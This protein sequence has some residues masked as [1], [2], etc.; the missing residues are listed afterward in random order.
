M[1]GTELPTVYP[2]PELGNL[3][4]SIC[5]DVRFPE[6]Y[7]H[8]AYKGADILFIPAAFTA[9]TGKDHGKCYCKQGQLKI[10][11]ML[12]RQPRQVNTMLYD[13]LTAML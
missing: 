4:I 2:S 13:R 6:L 5:Y 8:L 9:Y 11:A 7:R 1:A 12:L 3:G 10:L